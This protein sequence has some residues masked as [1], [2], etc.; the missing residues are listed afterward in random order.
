[1]RRDGADVLA[2]TLAK[3]AR[4]T[5]VDTPDLFDGGRAW[6]LLRYGGRAAAT[7]AVG[8]ALGDVPD[9]DADVVLA[10]LPGMRLRGFAPAAIEQQRNG[11]DASGCRLV[12][13]SSDAGEHLDA[14][15]GVST[16]QRT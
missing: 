5:M 9:D 13:T 14:H 16:R 1:M 10:V 8:A 12:V 2:G 11:R 15:L 6:E 4:L 3:A 7:G